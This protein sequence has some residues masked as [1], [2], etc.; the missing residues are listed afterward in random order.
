MI[1]NLCNITRKNCLGLVLI[2]SM[3]LYDAMM[4]AYFLVCDCFAMSSFFAAIN[5]KIYN[6]GS[7]QNWN[8]GRIM[9]SVVSCYWYCF[10]SKWAQNFQ[11]TASV[12]TCNMYV[13]Y[14][15]SWFLWPPCV[16]DADIIFLPC[17]FFFPSSFFFPRL[18][19]AVAHWMSAIL[20]HMVWP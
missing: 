12:Y 19:S 7:S 13:I 10:F 20:P 14:R 1:H 3:M 11:K 15:L 18:I 17:G 8:I 9:Y 4:L 5:Y 2:R 16:A 6:T